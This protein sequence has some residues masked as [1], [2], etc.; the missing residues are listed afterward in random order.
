MEC[1]YVKPLKDKSVI[2]AFFAEHGVEIP[3]G[4]L[5]LFSTIN[6]GRPEQNECVLK[7]GS[8]R[9]INNFLSFNEEDKENVYKAIRRV[10]EDNDKLV[11]F[12]KDPGG[13]YFCLFD[14]HVVFWFHE[15]GE[16]IDVAETFEQFFEIM[17]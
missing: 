15:D 9:V 7:D 16:I 10:S 11:P 14:G 12:A 3:Q 6:G 2:E 8:E 4:F 5:E 1:K 13:N 17:K